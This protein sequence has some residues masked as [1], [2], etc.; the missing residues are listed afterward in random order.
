M[1]ACHVGDLDSILRN[2]VRFFFS[3]IIFF[4]FIWDEERGR[5]L[6]HCVGY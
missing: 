2:G 1:S 3:P 4:F 5:G 6:G